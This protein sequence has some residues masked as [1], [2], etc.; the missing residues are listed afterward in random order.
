M[1]IAALRDGAHGHRVGGI[2]GTGVDGCRSVVVSKMYEDGKLDADVGDE[3]R[4]SSVRGESVKAVKENN[5]TKAL[6]RSQET[7]R[8]VRV[9][10]ASGGGWKGAPSHGIR[11]DGLYKV[12]SSRAVEKGEKEVYY[13]FELKRLPGQDPIDRSKPT[14][15][16]VRD[17]N[18]VSDGY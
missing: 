1:Q 6:L 4:Y 5:G 11:Y 17:F 18:R 14:P 15:S 13:Q 16:Q 10:R 8:P 2:S 12:V 7:Q 9:L 3:L